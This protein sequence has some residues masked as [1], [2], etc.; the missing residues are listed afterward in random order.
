MRGDRVP[1]IAGGHVLNALILVLAV[2]VCG[3]LEELTKEN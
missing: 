2:L 1:R 3:W